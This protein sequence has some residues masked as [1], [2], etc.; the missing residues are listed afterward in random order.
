MKHKFASMWKL[1]RSDMYILITNK[2]SIIHADVSGY[3][4]DI[5]LS[6]LK[7]TQKNLERAIKDVSRHLEKGK[8][9]G[10]NKNRRSKGSPEKSS[11]RS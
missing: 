6:I 7:V 1:F 4:Q 9:S 2:E 10:R 3:D 5:V 11:Q 8:D